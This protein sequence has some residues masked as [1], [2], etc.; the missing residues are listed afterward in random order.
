MHRL[1]VTKNGKKYLVN[2]PAGCADDFGVGPGA[3]VGV[4]WMGTNTGSWY[5]LYVTGSGAGAS[6]AISQS[7]LPYGDFAPG[8][9]LLTSNDGHTYQVYLKGNPPTVTFNVSQSVYSGSNLLSGSFAPASGKPDL[10]IKSVTDGQ[11]YMVYLTTSAGVT[12]ANVN[13]SYVSASWVYQ[14]GIY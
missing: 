13:P 4:L 8:F 7:A 12:T 3:S 14:S 1:V 5:Q 9:Q 6:L 10:L 11:F 2:T